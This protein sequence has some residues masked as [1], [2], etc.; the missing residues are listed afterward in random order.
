LNI[1]EKKD[2]RI[3]WRRSKVQELSSQGQNQREIAQIL[4][5][6]NGTVNGDLAYLRLQAKTNIRKYIDE[7]LPEEYEK[8]M[9]GLTSILKEA[10][11]A[12]QEAVDKREKIQPLSLAKECYSMKLDLLTNATV[13]DDA[14]RFV[15]EKAKANTVAIEDKEKGEKEVEDF[16]IQRSE[17]EIKYS[18]DSTTTTNQLF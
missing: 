7:R 15:L 10:W 14:V 9:V 13:V 2:R 1:K 5:V 8:C 18:N 16:D 11:T 3:E 4:Q 17:E 12:A 6:S